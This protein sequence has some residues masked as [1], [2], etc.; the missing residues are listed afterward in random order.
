MTAPLRIGFSP[1]PNDTFVFHALVHGSVR[2]GGRPIEP[3]VEDIEVLNRR[4]VDSSDPLEVSKLSVAALAR[5]LPRYVVLSAGAALGRGVGPLVVRRVAD[6]PDG[7]ADLARCT[8]AIPGEHTTAALLLRELAP[9][10]ARTVAMPFSRIMAAVAAG[11]VQAGVVIHEGRFTY[12]AHGLRTLADLGEV[13]ES[14]TGL[15]LPLGVIAAQRSLPRRTIEEID[16]ALRASV[17][18]AFARPDASDEYVRRHAQEMDPAVRRRHVE[19]YV[20]EESR[21]L[22]DRGRTAVEHLLARA[23]APAG[24]SPWG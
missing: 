17:E 18:A 16:A 6:G 1:C 8:V 20:N 22:S 7:L 5:A 11:E 23:G 13:W 15:P 4:A 10:P 2:P 3:V 19:L 14:A 9:P 21:A 24:L 12:Q